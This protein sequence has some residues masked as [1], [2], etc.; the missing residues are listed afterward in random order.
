MLPE[1]SQIIES[2]KN[3]EGVPL[4]LSYYHLFYSMLV[5]V[6]STGNLNNYK[7]R[8]D[9]CQHSSKICSSLGTESY[10]INICLYLSSMPKH[11]ANMFLLESG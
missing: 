4:K 2:N 11:L 10:K 9:H 5:P 1:T 8:T 3:I 6:Y 7:S